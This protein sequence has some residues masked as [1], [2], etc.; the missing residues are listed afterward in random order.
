MLLINATRFH[1]RWHIFVLH[2]CVLMQTYTYV[3][4][5]T[6]ASHKRHSFPHTLAHGCLI[7]CKNAFS[8]RHTRTPRVCLSRTHSPFGTS[9]H[10]LPVHKLRTSPRNQK[11][12]FVSDAAPCSLTYTSIHA[13]IFTHAYTSIHAC[14][15]VRIRTRSS[16]TYANLMSL[17][18][19]RLPNPLQVVA[20]LHDSSFLC[21][22]VNMLC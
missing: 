20:A 14:S 5:P 7:S 17:T 15:R 11:Y 1:T 19:Y 18:L 4:H 10:R 16:I 2:K 21:L 8:C 22:H 9:P 3:V 13:Y 6:R 12:I